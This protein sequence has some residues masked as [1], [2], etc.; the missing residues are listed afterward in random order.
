MKG[1]FISL[2]KRYFWLFFVSLYFFAISTWILTPGIPGGVDTN[3]HLFKI[4]HLSKYGLSS[5]W[6]HA[7]YGGYPFL[8]FYPPLS[9][10]MAAVLSLN[11]PILSLKIISIIFFSVTPSS[12]YFL[13]TNL[14]FNEK[15]SLLAAFLLGVSPVFIMN[16]LFYGR[17]PNV[18]AFP[19]VCFALGTFIHSYKKNGSFTIP[20]LI[21]GLLILIHHLSAFIG[22]FLISLFSIFEIVRSRRLIIVRLLFLVTLAALVIG[23]VWILPFIANISYYGQFFNPAMPILT[24]KFL[25]RFYISMIGLSHIMLSM[26]LLL[27]IF[28]YMLSSKK[29]NSVR[30]LLAFVFVAIIISYTLYAFLGSGFTVTIKHLLL[31]LICITFLLLI[32]LL[33]QFTESSLNLDINTV[34]NA[35]WFVIFFWLT[36]GPRAILFAIFPLSQTLDI[37]RFMLYASIP[38]SLLGARMFLF[39]IKFLKESYHSVSL[40]NKLALSLLLTIL[41]FSFV[42][43]FIQ[44]RYGQGGMLYV[45]DIFQKNQEIPQSLITYLQDSDAYGRILSIHSPSWI[46][47][48]PYY[49]NKPLID[50]W[51][52]QARFLYPFQNLTS[53]NINELIS[54]EEW[55]YEYLLQHASL[56]G[57]KWVLIGDEDKLQL[58]QPFQFRLVLHIDSLYLYENSKNISFIDIKK[59]KADITY[60]RPHP[61]TIVIKVEKTTQNIELLVKEVH[62]PYWQAETTENNVELK[63]SEIGFM[64]LSI[65]SDTM[66]FEI[67]LFYTYP[68]WQRI[69]PIFLSMFALLICCIGYF[70][71]EYFKQIQVRLKNF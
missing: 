71:P 55:V 53:Y 4:L 66:I 29:G 10:Y 24:L 63:K 21:M 11:N 19:L 26:G 47:S 39:L 15:E 33:P 46:Y 68:V 40:S 62:F 50:G 35:S 51:F 16:L 7:W 41:S 25:L 36:L 28:F 20:A 43:P 48:L 17:Y 9:Y 52:P 5:P 57:I 70:K 49:T 60:E 64:L 58:I 2:G 22:F 54:S 14:N 65:G 3:S 27:L 69:I 59:G 6:C 12:V 42:V 1:R 61:N 30:I 8:L 31:F 44:P 37:L 34:F 23:A 67:R 13:A 38:V 45:E 32:Y 56:Y 18:I